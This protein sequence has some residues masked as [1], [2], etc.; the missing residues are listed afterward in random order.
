MHEFSLAQGL[1]NQLKALAHDHKA[2]KIIKIRLQ[3]GSMSGIVVDSFEFGFEVLAQEEPLLKEAVLEIVH[4]KPHAACLK[5]GLTM[6]FLP[7]NLCCDNCGS[8]SIRRKGGDELILSQ[9][10]ME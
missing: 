7:E 5:C 10:E 6:D 4:S 1:V 3:V 9:V 8:A 2:G